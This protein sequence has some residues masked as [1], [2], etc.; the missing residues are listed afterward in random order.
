LPSVVV[1]TFLIAVSF[2]R[3]AL[4][5]ELLL[6]FACRGIVSVGELTVEVMTESINFIHNP[7]NSKTYFSL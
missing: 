3:G 4:L 2:V 7:F 6:Q 1:F 5:I